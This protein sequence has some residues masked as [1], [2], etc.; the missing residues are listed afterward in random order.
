MIPEGKF[1]FSD[2]NVAVN[3]GFYMEV[4]LQKIIHIM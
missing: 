3:I 4:Q 1:D 2:A